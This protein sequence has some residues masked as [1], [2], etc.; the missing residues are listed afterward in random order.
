MCD[1]KLWIHVSKRGV[2]QP[3]LDPLAR[4]VAVGSES[5]LTA[6]HGALV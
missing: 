1:K 5:G 4:T 6:L 2:S 3:L